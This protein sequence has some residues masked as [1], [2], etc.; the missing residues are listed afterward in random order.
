MRPRFDSRRP[1][2][3]VSQP[4]RS[5][6]QVSRLSEGSR[7]SEGLRLS[8][9][10]R[11]DLLTLARRAVLEAVLHFGLLD[12]PPVSDRLREP[13][14]AFVSLYCRRRLRGCIGRTNSPNGLAE[15]V[16]QCAIGAALQ[17]PRFQPLRSEEVAE[18]AIEISVLSALE[19]KKPEELEA[20]RHG[21]LVIR[22][23]SRG[24]LLPQL[25]A[26]RK[27]SLERFLEEACRKAELP[28][29]AWRDPTTS[30]CAFTAD[31]FSDADF[32]VRAQNAARIN[33]DGPPETSDGPLD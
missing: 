15:T 27:W 26:E 11:R 9:K 23:H 24:L 4:E 7:P 5:S 17:D 2:L 28:P 29:E 18:L 25:A 32:A 20:G 30:I 22:G 14:A 3:R 6:E 16:A 8:D 12:L 33:K 1:A 31:V 13:G 21:V 19:P 10:D